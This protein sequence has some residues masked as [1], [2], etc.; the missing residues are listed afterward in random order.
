MVYNVCLRTA[1]THFKQTMYTTSVSTDKDQ[2]K[3][4]QEEVEQTQH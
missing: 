1:T 3:A 2:T 4:E